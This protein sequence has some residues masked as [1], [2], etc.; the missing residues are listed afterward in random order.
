MCG[1]AGFLNFDYSNSYFEQVNTI[2]QHRGPDDQ[3][4]FQHEKVK[5]FHQRLS[6]IDISEAA[7]Q[8]FEKEGLVIVFNGEIYNYKNLRS[9][10]IQAGITF[11]TTSDT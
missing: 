1:I 2:Q 9:K 4:F 7:N 8:P 5:L 6:I 3:S 10:L 11:S